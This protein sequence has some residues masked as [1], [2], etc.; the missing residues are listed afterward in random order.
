MGRQR[1]FDIISTEWP[2]LSVKRTFDLG[3][4]RFLTGRVR[5]EADIVETAAAADVF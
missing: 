4:N 5:P 2:L 3:K 1:P